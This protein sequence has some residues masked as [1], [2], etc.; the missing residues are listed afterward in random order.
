MEIRDPI[1]GSITIDSSEIPIIEHPF[2]QRLRSIKQLGVSDYIFPGATHTRFLHSIGVMKTIDIT[3]DK[4]FKK[5]LHKSEFQKLRQTVKLA[6]LLH[7][8]GHAPL[9]HSTEIVMPN[10]SALKLPVE[11]LKKDSDYQATHEDYTIK[12]IVDSDLTSS[13]KKVTNKQG[14]IPEAVAD[15]IFGKSH[16]QDYFTIDNINYFPVLHQ[17]VSGE[18]DCDR[19]DYLLRD[20]YYC[21]VSYGKYDLDWLIDNLSYAVI[22]NKAYLSLREK[23]LTTFD[24]FLLSRFHMFM[25]VY[26]HYRSV[27]LEQMLYRFFT[28]CP[29]EYQIPAK[30]EEYVMHDDHYLLKKLRKS[31]NSWAQ[32][33]IANKIPPKIFELH[34]NY[35]ENKKEELLK[36]L[37]SLNVDYILCES[38]GR[39]SKYY[40][41]EKEITED[42]HIKVYRQYSKEYIDINQATDLYKKYSSSHAVSR[43]HLYPE[44]TTKEQ[45]NKI[46]EIIN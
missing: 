37:K 6:G 26:F 45:W 33:I 44:Q 3:F 22:D 34:G 17:M 27:C 21:G 30:I 15:L 2:F 11:Y 36:T 24:D 28:E 25:M 10:V 1:H 4:I 7:D 39:L 13:F 31:K 38:T 40:S 20:S 32:K 8:I 9:S 41:S 23:A 46:S 14:V 16:N 18:M 29:T 5:H 12:A 42:Y 19:M 43:I 35:G